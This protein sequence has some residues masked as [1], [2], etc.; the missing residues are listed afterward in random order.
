M[1]R[2]AVFCDER[3]DVSDLA[4]EVR[5]AANDDTRHHRHDHAPA[6]AAI[7]PLAD[8]VA[9]AERAAL[10]AALAAH[11]HNL[12]HTARA[13]VIDRNTVKRKLARY[14]LRE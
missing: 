6:S 11:A 13:L 1:L 3:V 4:P 7:A 2:W 5:G 10:T 12:T 9:A 8:V 14:D